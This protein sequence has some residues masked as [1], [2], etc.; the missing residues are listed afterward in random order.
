MFSVGNHLMEQSFKF[1]PSGSETIAF[2]NT[3]GW[4]RSEIVSV[5]AEQYSILSNKFG[6]LHSQLSHDGRYLIPLNG[7]PSMGYKLFSS[8]V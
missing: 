5:S 7:V 8:A 4:S 3:L 2:V 6:E 1:V